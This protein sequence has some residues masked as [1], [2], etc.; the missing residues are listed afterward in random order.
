MLKLKSIF[1]FK[2]QK[3][4]W[5]L[6][7]SPQNT[8]GTTTGQWS[9]TISSLMDPL[10]HRRILQPSPLTSSARVQ[11][12]WRAAR[13]PLI[14]PQ[15]TKGSRTWSP[16]QI[17]PVQS[18][19]WLDLSIPIHRGRV[20]SQGVRVHP[21]P[22]PTTPVTAAPCPILVKRWGRTLFGRT[23]RW[24]RLWAMNTKGNSTLTG[25]P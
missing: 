15:M 8:K 6:Y 20:A 18:Q 19:A 24:E 23:E 21:S 25:L 12:P 5:L 22:W 17:P 14:T 1:S 11:D 13:S 4:Y 2:Y 10:P 16:T 9:T 7:F 3:H